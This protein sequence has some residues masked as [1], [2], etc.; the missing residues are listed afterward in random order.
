MTERERERE[1]EKKKEKRREDEGEGKVER[2]DAWFFFLYLV[3]RECEL[4]LRMTDYLSTRRG[5][6]MW[7]E[8]RDGRAVE[9]HTD[10]SSE[11]R[12]TID[13]SERERKRRERERKKSRWD[14]CDPVSK[15]ENPEGSR[16]R[17]SKTWEGER[18]REREME[19][20]GKK[21]RKRERGM[22]K[23]IH[24]RRIWERKERREETTNDVGFTAYHCLSV[25]LN[26][27][28]LSFSF[29][30][31]PSLS[32]PSFSEREE[33]FSREI[34]WRT[35]SEMKRELIV[36]KNERKRKREVFL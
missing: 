22:E 5:K 24:G 25:C 19:R 16:K 31:F 36:W 32:L 9:S 14:P 29:F 10:C 34:L 12:G 13:R 11:T 23:G 33:V 21:K 2:S 30:C 8:E 26:R 17:G 1:K 28:L 15:I 3:A 4:P 18:G 27:E 6:T 20:K 35:E 7:K